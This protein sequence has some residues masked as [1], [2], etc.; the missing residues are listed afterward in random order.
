VEAAWD[1]GLWYLTYVAGLSPMWAFASYLWCLIVEQ[2]GFR[3]GM[4]F[5]FEDL[6]I[7]STTTWET[8]HPT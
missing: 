3:I 1:L 6:L 8:Q 2:L 4:H 7:C 5:F